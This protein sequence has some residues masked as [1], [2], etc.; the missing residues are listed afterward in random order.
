MKSHTYR[1]L[2]SYPRKL[3]AVTLLALLTLCAQH[4]PSAFA[5]CPNPDGCVPPGGGGDDDPPP[6]DD[7]PPAEDH[8]CYYPVLMSAEVT[9]VHEGENGPLGYMYFG[10]MSPK[11]GDLPAS[12]GTGVPLTGSNA[13]PQT[14][15]SYNTDAW[16]SNFRGPHRVVG[17]T[18]RTQWE[19][20][21][22]VVDMYG[23]ES[24]S[25]GNGG[26]PLVGR[27]YYFSPW[28]RTVSAGAPRPAT[29]SRE[30]DVWEHDECWGP[31]C[32]EDDHVGGFRIFGWACEQEVW[33]KGYLTGWTTVQQADV[34]G[35]IAAIDYKLWCYSCKNTY[36]S[37]STGIGWSPAPPPSGGGDGG[38]GGG[39][40]GGDLPP[41]C[42][43]GQHCCGGTAPDGSCDG[44]CIPLGNQCQ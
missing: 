13:P 20:N 31:F 17:E 35:S 21:Q 34:S 42:P 19:W 39:G 14:W 12:L 40:G 9:D 8:Y 25:W 23:S 29:G 4:V 16:A 11:S 15:Y 6:S 30:E 27:P 1:G 7:P 43:S 33:S 26:T 2:T 41:A 44:Q 22:H 18:S 28:C 3:A 24:N 10:D 36:S 32:N 38:G 5:R 37:C